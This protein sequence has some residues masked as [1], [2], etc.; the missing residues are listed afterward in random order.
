VWTQRDQ[1]QAYQF[2]RRRLVSALVCADANHPASPARR[3]VL[4]V[5]L[6]VAVTLLAS[7]VFGVI[8][9][10]RPN[11]PADWRRGGQVIVE[12]ETGA[13]FVLGQDDRLHPVLNFASARLL[14]GGDGAR[15]AVVPAAA[16]AGAPRGSTIGIPGAPDSLPEAKRLLGGPWTACSRTSPDRPDELEPL[17]TVLLG[18]S[19]VGRRL[20]GSEALYVRLA[21]GERFLVTGGH[22]HLLPDERSA[23]VL[24]YAAAAALPVSR[25]WLNTVPTGRDL[26]TVAVPDSGESGPDVGGQPTK[27]GQVLISS[28][29][30]GAE[31]YYVVRADGLAVVTETEAILVLGAPEN[32][33]A[34]D[35]GDPRPI[36]VP[37]GDIAEARRL[38]PGPADPAGYPRRRPVPVQVEGGTATVCAT[39]FGLSGAG[40]VLGDRLPLDGGA[41]VVPV[42][43]PADTASSRTA[44]EVFVP[45]GSGAVVAEEPAPGAPSGVLYVI[46]DTGLRY[47]VGN[48]EAI[49]ALGYG[50]APRHRVPATVL[51]LFPSGPTLA[52][53]AAA[54]PAT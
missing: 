27:I 26:D 45:G 1:V 33:A 17:S 47:P 12:K 42:A 49:R 14:A 48:D 39:E 32:A 16:L 53:D 5:A 10:L 4:G 34:Y 25:S 15:A 6:G 38:A 29:V 37:A 18:R 35:Y 41:R 30:D 11:R 9:L 24:G 23:T 20:T 22:R 13:R 46:T 40:I 2:L 51:A 3:A 7:A 28:G 19:P 21:S 54:R 52:T 43:Q 44:A 31:E 50:G 36:P 8:G